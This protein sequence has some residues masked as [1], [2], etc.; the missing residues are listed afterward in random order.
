MEHRELQPIYIKQCEFVDYLTIF[1]ESKQEIQKNIYIPM[2]ES[3][4][5]QKTKYKRR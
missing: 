5:E 1:E 3:P 2:E 4:I